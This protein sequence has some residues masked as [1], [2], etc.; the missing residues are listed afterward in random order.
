MMV[1]MTMMMITSLKVGN[2]KFRARKLPL[3][4]RLLL[5]TIIIIITI[6]TIITNT[7]II[8]TII[9]AI[10]I[11]IITIIIIIIF[12]PCWICRVTLSLSVSCTIIMVIMLNL[13]STSLLTISLCSLNDNLVEQ[14]TRICWVKSSSPKPWSPLWQRLLQAAGLWSEETK[15]QTISCLRKRIKR[16]QNSQVPTELTD[17]SW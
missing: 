7:I 2:P 13:S 9:I 5:H 15:R 6:I 10:A 3:C 8:I 12:L 17:I 14:L 4:V 16:T 11:I 1:T